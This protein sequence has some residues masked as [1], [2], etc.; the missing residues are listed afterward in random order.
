MPLRISGPRRFSNQ[1]NLLM[2]G[3]FEK[4]TCKSLVLAF[5]GAGFI[6]VQIGEA[7]LIRRHFSIHV[8]GVDGANRLASATLNTL[9]RVD[10]ELRFTIKLVNTV[11]RANTHA[12]FVFNVNTRFCNNERH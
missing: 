6:S 7:S 8:N 5:Q 1:K 10:V 4:K 2:G 9:I 3:S 11:Y 12:S